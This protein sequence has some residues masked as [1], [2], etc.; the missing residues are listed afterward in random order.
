MIRMY[1]TATLRALWKER[2]TAI[3]N[4]TGLAIGL[5]CAIIVLLSAKREYDVNGIFQNANRI[6]RVSSDWK[7]PGMGIYI[8][9]FAPVGP[10]MQQNIPGIER[11][12][13]VWSGYIVLNVAGRAFRD[14]MIIADTSYFQVFGL[15]FLEGNAQDAFAEPNAVVITE[16]LA[17]KCFGRT[18]VLGE[19][20]TL[21]PYGG[22]G[23][24]DFKVTG[25]LRTFTETSAT[26]FGGSG[27]NVFVSTRNLTD[28]F[29][30][31]AFTDWSS[32]Y[33]VTFVEL[34]PGV[35]AR[36]VQSQLNRLL[37]GHC[38]SEF[39]PYVSLVLDPLTDIHLTDNN[40][41]VQHRIQAQLAFALFMVLLVGIN[42]VNL[43]TARA[44]NRAKEVGIRKVMGGH[45]AQLVL[46]FLTESIVLALIAFIAALGLVDI[47]N[48][49]IRP[50]LGMQPLPGIASD[51]GFF[52]MLVA[53]ALLIGASAGLYPAFV[54]SSFN[55]SI[56][57][58]EGASGRSSARVRRAL[59]VVQ[60]AGAMFL[61][62]A[63]AV[64][65]RQL[66]FLTSRDLGFQKEQVYVIES[67]PR[68]WN[69][70]GIQ[71][72]IAFRDRLMH[73]TGVVS[74]SLCWDVPS[75]GGTGSFNLT[76]ASRPDQKP[77]V[78][79][80]LT[81]DDKYLRTLSIP[82]QTGTFLSD[83]PV[84][85]DSSVAVVL[86]EAAVHAL[87]LRQPVGERLRSESGQLFT[88]KGVTSDFYQVAL[89]PL[90]TPMAF[91]N[92]QSAGI[93]R[94]LAIRLQP[95]G[96]AATIERIQ[97]AWKETN[98]DTPLIARFMDDIVNQQYAAML[99]TR[100]LGRLS[101]GLALFV[102]CLGL[103]GLASYAVQKRTKEIGIRKVLGASI[104]QIVEIF[105]REFLL[106]VLIAAVTA[107]PIVWFVMNSWLNNFAERMNIDWSVF[108]LSAG[109]LVFLSLAT[110]G[111]QT[112]KAALRN[113][114][115][116]LRSE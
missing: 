14:D 86:N 89:R 92:V 46:Q 9:T 68:Q 64:V 12:T 1:L 17:R 23:K 39:R 36:G 91:V 26:H 57:L 6:Y 8:T 109:G 35:E 7:E 61:M 58:R 43:S 102:A 29:P 103:F 70:E 15:P 10:L 13:R 21:K 38:P 55:P 37:D 22:S 42:Y 65:S 105:S 25:V 114:S 111:S 96:V 115:E 2:S 66:D 112:L 20:I 48:S 5:A 62:V 113:P 63:S 106:L 72:Q 59:V 51:V 56:A 30:A 28:F 16:Q 78:V 45:R 90:N 82:L 3:L 47:F 50:S 100:A 94:Y 74:A 18:D 85:S 31:S 49:L 110:V 54:L 77:I 83:Q 33:I 60:F 73:Q 93:Y 52:F 4:L 84:E 116:A 101:T 41:Q 104:P 108:V 76:A 53:V 71:R 87:G 80:Q 98:P 69:P 32:R 107:S 81:V 24:R 11:T 34:K 95:S 99:E 75:S 19:T 97:N 79:T 88:V 40:A 44:L 27:N 67:M